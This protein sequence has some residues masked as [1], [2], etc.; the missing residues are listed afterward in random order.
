MLFEFT[1][2]AIAVAQLMVAVVLPVLVGLVTTRVTASGL[3]AVILAALA[4]ISAMITE[5][6]DANMA[7]QAYDI[8]QGLINAIGTFVIAVAIHYGLWKPTGVSQR[9]QETGPG[10]K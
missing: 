4:V 9:A 10:I 2:D 6:V 3:K 7:G 5:A 1:V 8:G